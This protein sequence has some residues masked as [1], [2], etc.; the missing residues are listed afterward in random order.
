LTA[1]ILAYGTP[2]TP[3]NAPAADRRQA[4]PAPPAAGGRGPAQAPAPA[5]GRGRARVFDR[6]AI[7]RARTIFEP[8]CG[9]CHGNDA[10][11]RAGGPDLARS[12]VVLYDTGGKELGEYLRTGAPERG[13]PAFPSLQPGQV[14]DIA[15]FL[16]ERVEAARNRNPI[17]LRASVVGDPVAGAAYFNGPGRCSTCHSVTGDLAGIGAK[18]DPMTLQDRIVNPRPQGPGGGR[19]AAPPAPSRS[20]RTVTVTLASGENASG[21]LLFISEFAVTLLDQAGQRRSFTRAG[22]VP[23][24]VVTDPLQAHMDLLRQYT[25]R[26]MHNVTAYLVTMK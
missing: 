19:G 20:A 24:V 14:A 17:D 1:G 10:R 6:E 3:S 13:M 26:D 7:A 23:K 12:L 9:F 11:G 5:A 16:H 25:D 22:G 8:T 21:T 4:G 15:E 2:A 18:Y